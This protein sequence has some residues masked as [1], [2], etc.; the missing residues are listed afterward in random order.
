LMPRSA[1]SGVVI[2]MNLS[3]VWTASLGQITILQK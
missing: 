1:V 3:L 2:G